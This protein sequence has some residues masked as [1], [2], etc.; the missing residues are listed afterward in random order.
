MFF[1]KIVGVTRFLDPTIRS[2]VV[3]IFVIPLM[4]T[5]RLEHY[6]AQVANFDFYKENG[7]DAASTSA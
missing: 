2:K 5:L 3:V 1:T 7:K 6:S 4:Y